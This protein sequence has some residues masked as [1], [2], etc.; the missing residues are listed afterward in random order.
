VSPL[1]FLDF[2]NFV[3]LIQ[4]V[5]AVKARRPLASR[6]GHTNPAAAGPGMG[7]SRMPASGNLEDLT[8]IG[9]ILFV[10][11]HVF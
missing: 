1:F 4:L 11:A 8:Q 10:F 2:V 7:E 9:Q 6:Q 5:T 3:Q